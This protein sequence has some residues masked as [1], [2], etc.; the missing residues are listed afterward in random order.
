M[1]CEDSRANALVSILS[2][3]IFKNEEQEE[4]EEENDDYDEVSCCSRSRS[5]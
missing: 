4:E 2:Y 3:K 1:D 5:C